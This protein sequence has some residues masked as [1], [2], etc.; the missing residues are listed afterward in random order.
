MALFPCDAT[1][2]RY[3]GAQQT[4][5]PA[6]VA[7]VEQS[8]RKLRLCGQHFRIYAERL[9]ERAN[10]AQMEF[11]AALTVKCYSCGK[12]VDDSEWQFFVTAYPTKEERA[13]YWAPLHAQ[14]VGPTLEDWRLDLPQST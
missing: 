9:F 7:G 5:Y 6:V 11:D 2:H 8:R 10:N 3:P 4:M 1:G 13:D 12:P 14:C